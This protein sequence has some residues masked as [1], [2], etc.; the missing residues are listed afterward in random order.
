MDNIIKKIDSLLKGKKD[1][2][3]VSYTLI[4]IYYEIGKYIFNNKKSYKIIYE[5]EDTL[6]NR[7][8]LLIGFTRRNLNN[9]LKFYQI[10]KDYDINKLKNIPW[11]IHLIIMKQSNKNELI[12]Y[13]LNYNIDK[14]N[15]KKIIKDK[16]DLKYTSKEKKKEDS[17][18]LEIISL[19]K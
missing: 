19:N 12:N 15:L 6:R 11:G 9:M 4:E 10:Y 8:G 16:F 5:I 7:Y 3:I 17:M 18:T 14:D 1:Y 2:D 13:C